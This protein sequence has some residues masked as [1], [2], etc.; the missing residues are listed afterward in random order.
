MTKEEKALYRF[1][2]EPAYREKVIASVHKE[3]DSQYEKRIKLLRSEKDKLI[4]K[5]KKEIERIAKARWESVAGDKLLVNV[6]EGK[7]K[8][9]QGEFTFSDIKGAEPNVQFVN[10]VVTEEKG[11]SKKHASVGGGVV[12][13]LIGGVPGAIIGGVGLGKTNTNGTSTQTEI[14]ICTHI[15]VLVNVN[16]FV[17]EI[18]VLSK[19]VEQSSSDFIKAQNETQ[20]IISKLIEI[21]KISMPI[22]WLKVEDEPSVKEFDGKIIDKEKEIQVAIDDKPT[23]KIPDTYRTTA[24]KD[25]S[26]E[27]YLSYLD[28]VKE[29]VKPIESK[30]VKE[31]PM[32][33][34][35][36]VKKH[37]FP[38][39]KVVH[40]IGSILG[41]ATSIFILIFVLVAAIQSRIV[42]AILLTVSALSINPLI[43]K[44]LKSKMNFLR[45]W[46]VILLF[47]VTCII[48]IV[49]MV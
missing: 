6:T 22:E 33:K 34:K 4:S 7:V 46:M 28:S 16:G 20:N 3:Q 37:A 39:K 5:R 21:S 26:D 42:S 24:Q 25:M 45:K 12:G 38:I 48:G 36:R 18:V 40:I 2:N 1:V 23:Y 31:I 14:P 10:R 47:I 19:Q 11:K 49:A 13:G 32:P 27:E 41:W 30:I 17:L 8:I 43:Y 15:G 9:N 35:E 44:C 29:P